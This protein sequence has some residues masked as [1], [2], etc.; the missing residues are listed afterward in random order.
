MTTQP[1]SVIS[2]VGPGTGSALARRFAA[3]GHRVA[4]LARNAE[5]LAGLERELPGAKS[6]PCDVS[7]AGQVEAAAE[8]IERELGAPATLVHNA[9]GGAFGSFLEIDPAVLNRN[10][11]INTMGLLYLARRFAPAMVR[12]GKG[13]I[14][15][16]GNTSALRGKAAFAG[17]APTKAAQ[18]ILAEAMARELGPKGVH[19]AYI[20]IDAVIDVPWTR[21]R[22]KDK[23]DEFFI[24][25]T[26]IA[27]EA[28][29]LT[30]QT[31]SSWSFNVE[32]RPYCE[33]W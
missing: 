23:P 5:R 25:P 16:T 19:V 13:N 33:T 27:E 18:R 4:M 12:A 8:R 24:K 17:F 32:L 20:V 10:F 22:Y 30:Q 15:V 1:I 14:I 21:Q 31:R 7:D 11:Q 9:V 6:Y 2:G 28:W 26:A 3:G 29:H